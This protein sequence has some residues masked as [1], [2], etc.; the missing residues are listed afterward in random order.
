MSIE[1]LGAL[2][3]PLA[4]SVDAVGSRVT[5]NARAVA[6]PTGAAGVTE[7]RQPGPP[8]AVATS[9]VLAGWWSER[10]R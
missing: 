6:Q 9:E 2:C 8:W 3:T 7:A 10:P 5:C 4:L 1:T